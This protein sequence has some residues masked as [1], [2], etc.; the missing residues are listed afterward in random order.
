MMRLHADKNDVTQRIITQTDTHR[1]RV[2]PYIYS[3]SASVWKN[4]Y[5]SKLFLAQM[6][7]IHTLIKLCISVAIHA[8]YVQIHAC[9]FM[10]MVGIAIG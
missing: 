8:A 7:N 3:F 4:K 2:T 9:V 10:L 6:N 1:I 5:L